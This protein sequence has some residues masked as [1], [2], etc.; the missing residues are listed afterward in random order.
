MPPPVP[1]DAFVGPELGTGADIKS[2]LKSLPA[3]AAAGLTGL[4]GSLESLFRSDA[5]RALPTIGE[6]GAKFGAYMPQSFPGKVIKGLAEGAPLAPLGAGGAIAKGAQWALPVLAGE[7]AGAAFAGTPTED[8]ARMVGGGL[9]ALGGIGAGVR[10]ATA[11]PRAAAAA[12]REAMPGEL[13]AAGGR[14]F[15]EAAN[16]PVTIPAHEVTN[17]VAQAR[18]AL[19]GRHFDEVA[20]PM[21]ARTL[22]RLEQGAQA[23]APMTAGDAVSLRVAL[24]QIGKQTQDFRPTPQAA[25]A[26]TVRSELDQFLGRQSPELADTIQRA[27][28][29]Y[30]AGRLGETVANKQNKAELMASAANS[31]MN[32]ENSIRSQLRQIATNPARMR[33]FDQATQGLI[34]QAIEGQL[35]GNVLR[36]IGNLMGG[37][38]GL[39]AMVSGVGLG[40]AFGPVAAL[41]PL[42]GMGAK[43][44]GNRTATRAIEN[45]AQSAM[46]NAPDYARLQAQVQHALGAVRNSRISASRRAAMTQALQRFAESRGIQVAATV[47]ADENQQ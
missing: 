14:G 40:H 28:A 8:T 21:V 37:G 24:N 12:A 13:V 10:A 3:Y 39:G 5:N 43:A 31:G 17:F 19:A 22:D 7:G 38:G 35:P 36:S 20:A 4:P 16:L 23:G 15:N 44:I 45:I 27:S 6:Q 42:V 11:A 34:R 26:G 46:R 2:A 1:V 29:N 41:A 33:Q 25:A 47:H 18:N 32:V 9:G 30:R